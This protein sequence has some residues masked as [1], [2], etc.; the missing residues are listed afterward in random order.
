MVQRRDKTTIDYIVIALNPLLIVTMIASLVYFL[1]LCMY[2]GEFL[3]RIN[4]ILFLFIVAA[5]GIARIAIEQGRGR[6]TAFALALGAATLL[7]TMRF[8]G[9]GVLMVVA[10]LAVIWYLADR[11]TI[12]CTLIDEHSDA[13]G[14]GLMQ[15]GLFGNASIQDTDVS[16]DG[17]TE[18]P[19]LPP[20]RGQTSLES[21][22]SQRHSKP[23]SGHRPGMW[24]LYL[25]FAAIPLY[26]LGQVLLP[27]DTASRDSALTSLGIYLA[28]S[29]LL[30][31]T[32]SFLGMRRY[33]RQRGV[34]MPAGIS[35]RWLVAGAILVA[36]LLTLCFLLPMPGKLL[37]SLELPASVRSPEGLQSNRQGWGDEGVEKGKPDDA[38]GGEGE[39]GSAGEKSGGEKSDGKKSGG[40]KSGGEKSGGEKSG[41]EKSGGEKSGGEKS[42]GE[43]SDGK[44][45]GGE[46]SGGEKSGG[47]KSGG[48]KSGGEKSGGE[49]SGGEKSGGEKSGGEKSGGEKSDSDA[50]PDDDSEPASGGRDPKSES[51]TGETRDQQG[52]SPS[53]PPPPPPNDGWKMPDILSKLSGLLR[54]VIFAVLAGIVAFYGMRHWDEIVQWFRELLGGWGGTE[55]TAPQPQASAAVAPAVR[56]RPFSTYQN[57]LQDASVSMER[58]VVISFNALN[59]W[60][61]EHDCPRPDQLTPSEFTQQLARRFPTQSKT[62]TLTAEMY[63]VVVYGNRNVNPAHRKTLQALW[64]FMQQP[65]DRSPLAS[66]APDKS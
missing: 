26:G 29:L 13:S 5:V 41:G 49:K 31:V 55:P 44:K 36:G 21:P 53:E 15:G 30:L 37:A 60:A 9:E 63:N 66:V 14:A 65:V 7:S 12:D 27:S 2:R 28:S 6:A 64:T 47:E 52:N 62:I 56:A 43:K 59:A 1:T 50:E 35:V 22:Q 58:A 20:A 39:Q 3:A 46:K 51:D 4:Y 38:R 34:D 25:A 33:L 45:S 10:L 19:D 18:Q 8:V 16:L 48:E 57:P 61:R 23:K 17:T 11:I 42:G 40:E 54:F 32:T 24:I